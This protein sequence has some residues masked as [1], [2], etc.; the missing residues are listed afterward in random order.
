[1]KLKSKQPPKFSTALSICASAVLVGAL[2]ATPALA[3]P[4][5]TANSA[6]TKSANTAQNSTR[7][8]SANSAQNAQAKNTKANSASAKN[9]KANSGRNATNSAKIKNVK[10]PPQP[11]K[12]QLKLAAK[13]KPTA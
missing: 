7:A 3:A 8:K 13:A 2:C 10:S 12:I 11:L 1:M 6:R 5:D 4:S 9:T